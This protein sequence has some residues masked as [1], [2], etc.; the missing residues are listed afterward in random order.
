MSF[1]CVNGD[2]LRSIVMIF[3]RALPA[4][5]LSAV[6]LFWSIDFRTFTHVFSETKRLRTVER[7]QITQLLQNW[8]II[9]VQYSWPHGQ[10]YFHPDHWLRLC[11][12]RRCQYHRRHNNPIRCNATPLCNISDK[13]KFYTLSIDEWITRS[14]CHL[15]RILM[16]F[17]HAVLLEVDKQTQTISDLRKNSASKHNLK[18]RTWNQ[19]VLKW[20]EM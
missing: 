15:W 20:G 7:S 9:P 12:R 6:Y 16:A 5:H 11:C 10:R 3:H 1:W 8:L 18:M 13:H 4:S 19:G 2:L 17:Q 14:L